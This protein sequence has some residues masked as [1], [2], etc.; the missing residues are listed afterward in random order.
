MNDAATAE[1]GRRREG[2]DDVR[3]I[4]SAQNGPPLDKHM[5]EAQGFMDD[6]RSSYALDSLFEK[7]ITRPGDHSAFTVEHGL[8][9]TTNRAGVRVL[10][11]PGVVTRKRRLTE[12]VI[13]QAHTV[14][15]HLGAQKTSEYVR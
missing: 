8:I 13:D 1:A 7:V 6:V 15:G 11:I 4:D 5:N 12:R 14:L 10:C 2:D 9:Y 3:I